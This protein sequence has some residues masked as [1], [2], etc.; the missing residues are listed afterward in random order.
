MPDYR[1]NLLLSNY[2]MGITSI[3]WTD[4]SINPF[5]A[6]DSDG[7][8]GHY[9]EKVSAGCTNCY[10][11]NFQ[12]RFKMPDYD[13]RNREKVELFLDET[14]LQEVLRRKAPTKWFWCDMTDMFMDDYPFSWIIKCFDV[15]AKTPQHTHQILT[16]RPARMK[17]FVEKFQYW[18][19]YAA[20]GMP[21][22][23][24]LGVSVEDQK[25]ADERILIL[26]DTPAAVRWISAE[27]LLGV[28][29][30]EKLRPPT[31][32]W[33]DCLNNRE[34][35]GPSVFEGRGRLTW[36]VVG[37]ESGPKARECN[38]DWIYSIVKQCRV[39]NVPCFVKQLGA[40]PFHSAKREGSTSYYLPISDRKGK[41]IEEFPSDIAVREFPFLFHQS[42]NSNE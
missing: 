5:R 17:E 18:E 7:H 4:R 30:L 25:T 16:K 10:A 8:V 13:V 32:T 23:I 3:E 9:C 15:M 33:L 22:N 36:V 39:A 21:K 11:S 1:Y 28:I 6:R 2:N 20:I 19:G 40:K 26:L 42:L 27:P 29:D 14:K 41:Y 12:K 31:A 24:W 38:V 37:G 35:T 34:H